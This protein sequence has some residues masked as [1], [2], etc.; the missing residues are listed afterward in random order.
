MMPGY[1]SFKGSKGQTVPARF[2]DEQM[3]D[4]A[5]FVLDKAEKN[6]Q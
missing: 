5:K 4:I 6:W 1:G 2:T 3:I